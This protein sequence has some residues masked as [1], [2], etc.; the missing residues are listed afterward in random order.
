MNVLSYAWSGSDV[1]RL[2]TFQTV[3]D[4]TLTCVRKTCNTKHGKLRVPTP[5]NI[6]PKSGFFIR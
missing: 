3:N 5:R 1:T 2:A 4:A 6:S